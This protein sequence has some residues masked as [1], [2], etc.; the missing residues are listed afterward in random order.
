M[1]DYPDHTAYLFGQGLLVVIITI[2]SRFQ[3]TWNYESDLDIGGNT[4]MPV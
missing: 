1:D 2:T 3:S 4:K